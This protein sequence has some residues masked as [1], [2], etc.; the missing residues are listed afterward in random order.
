MKNIFRISIIII[1]IFISKLFA[2]DLNVEMGA[3]DDFSVFG[4]EGS[5]LDPDVEIKGFTV[6]GATQSA[7][8]A[9][10]PAVPGN[11]IING[12]LGVSSG[13]YIAGTSTFSYVSSITIRGADAIFINGGTSGQLLK[14]HS[15]GYLYWAN[16]E[17]GVAGSGLQYRI[18]MWISDTVLSTSV[19]HQDG[20]ENSITLL[21]G[22]TLTVT[23]NAFSVGGST[24]VVKEGKVGIGTNNPIY[25]LVVSSGAGENG[26]IVAITTGTSEMIRITG[27]GE[28]YASKFI[29][30]GSGLIN[31]PGD[32]LGN[33]IATQ[34][35]N[36]A[37]K[38]I[39]N[40]SS[41]TITGSGVTGTDPLFKVADSTMVV[42]NNGNVGIGTTSPTT[43]FVVNNGSV[44][45]TGTNANLLVAGNVGIGTTSPKAKLDVN[46]G[47]V[48]ISGSGS[49]LI[50][51]S[52]DGS[53]CL[54]IGVDNSGNV[55]LTSVTCP[56]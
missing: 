3:T 46:G 40:V 30:D 51:R 1:T 13:A 11:V 10:I 56:S 18:P 32:N 6:F 29:G 38:A 37:N 41:M 19:I 4:I 15:D 27:A 39:D 14:K 16:D 22:S 36:M 45:V 21:F 43:K 44:T 47:D 25:N 35:L 48:Y 50:V 31:V 49:G 8:T 26:V 28:I 24:F 17:G 55:T 42:L 34:A 12:V 53:R 5:Y 23:G 54:K 52:P 20:G 9:N 7:Y 33:H 2:G